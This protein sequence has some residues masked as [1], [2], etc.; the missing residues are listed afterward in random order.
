MAR[1]V[2]A[3]TTMVQADF[4]QPIVQPAPQAHLNF[5]FGINSQSSQPVFQ[6]R[7]TQEQQQNQLMTNQQKV[8][9]P[10]GQPMSASSSAQQ[11]QSSKGV[12][13]GY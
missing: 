8:W 1:V 12:N 6:V 10:A 13:Q 9:Q 5:S 3:A 4:P 11:S 2:S 7:L